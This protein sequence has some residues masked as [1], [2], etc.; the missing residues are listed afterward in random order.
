MARHKR[1]I[2]GALLGIFACFVFAS[3]LSLLRNLVTW[4]LK[5]CI[6][7][8][9]RPVTLTT[10]LSVL[11]LSPLFVPF[12]CAASFSPHLKVEDP[13]PGTANPHKLD[14]KIRRF[15]SSLLLYN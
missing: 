10:A 4:R 11:S 12:V 7:L 13:V 5:R 15:G 3:S 14:F 6:C 2:A 8:D 1:K 9:R